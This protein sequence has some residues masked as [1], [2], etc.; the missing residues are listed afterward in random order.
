MSHTLSPLC[1]NKEEEEE[2]E[3]EEEG[4]EEEC[5]GGLLW[6]SSLTQYITRVDDRGWASSDD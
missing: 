6:K 4:W 5:F 1:D 3:E 2:E